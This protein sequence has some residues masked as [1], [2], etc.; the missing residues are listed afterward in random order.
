MSLNVSGAALEQPEGSGEGEVAGEAGT[1]TMH[2]E[3]RRRARS[4]TASLA[5]VPTQPPSAAPETGT[6][7]DRNAA[8][9]RA[10]EAFRGFGGRP[11]GLLTGRSLLDIDPPA[12][13]ALW[14]AHRLAAKRIPWPAVAAGRTAWG[15]VHVLIV[16]AAYGIGWVLFSPAWTFTAVLIVTAWILWS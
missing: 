12:V 3:T 4:V 11:R 15:A 2:A 5:A 16:S 6:E 10:R 7:S 1:G 8:F 14:A 13:G 9:D